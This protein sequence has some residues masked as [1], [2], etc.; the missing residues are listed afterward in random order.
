MFK[1]R[2]TILSIL[3]ALFVAVILTVQGILIGVRFSE[4]RLIEKNRIFVEQLTAI[5]IRD[6]ELINETRQKVKLPVAP[7]DKEVAILR[8][9]ITTTDHN[10]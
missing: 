1:T 3:F 10:K 8:D 5:V 7:I 6:R 2:D 4:Q 9:T